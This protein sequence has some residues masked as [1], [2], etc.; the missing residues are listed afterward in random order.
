MSGSDGFEFLAWRS[1]SEKFGALPVFV[2]SGSQYQVEIERAMRL[3]ATGHIVKP[4]A[5]GELKATVERVWKLGH[6]VRGQTC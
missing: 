1:R 4:L 6:Q 3:G 5:F 2:F